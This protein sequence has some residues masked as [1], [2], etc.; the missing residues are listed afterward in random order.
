M[1]IIRRLSLSVAIAALLPATAFAQKVT[2]DFA[3]DQNFASLKTFSFKDSPIEDPQIAQT[4]TYDDPFVKKR[5]HEAV[6]S[7]LEGRGM[8]RNDQHPDVYITTTRTFRKEYIL[9]GPDGWAGPFPGPY[10]YVGW[11]WGYG[12]GPTYV[13]EVIIGTLT[14]DIE[15][16][17]SGELIWRGIGERTVHP[18]S[19]PER[20]T[21]RIAEEV[22]KIF[23]NYPPPGARM[24]RTPAT[25]TSPP[26]ES[27]DPDVAT[28]QGP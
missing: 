9:Y 7:H 12:Y 3:V 28:R 26:V 22:T 10:P 16:A 27:A 5:T 17:S 8:T 20:R 21:A 15:K 6:A 25:V 14:V 19:K 2:Y 11:G 1:K 4:T 24:T 13:E 23:R 18:M